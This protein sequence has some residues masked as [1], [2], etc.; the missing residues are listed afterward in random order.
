MFHAS[1][2]KS[3]SMTVSFVVV[4]GSCYTFLYDAKAMLKAY[5]P[6]QDEPPRTV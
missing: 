1:R 4:A 6:R 5:W 2:V 3:T